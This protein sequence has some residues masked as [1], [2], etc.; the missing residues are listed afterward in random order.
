[1]TIDMNQFFQ[2]HLDELQKV[3]I[4][5]LFLTRKV[6]H[7]DEALSFL[8]A[9]THDSFIAYELDMLEENEANSSHPMYADVNDAY[10]AF[11][12]QFDDFRSKQDDIESLYTLYSKTFFK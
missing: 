4:E 1:M 11:R 9:L 10:D 3:R 7:L 5:L 12:K 8:Q 6:S 2:Q